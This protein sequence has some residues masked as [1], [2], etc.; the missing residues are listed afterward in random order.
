MATAQA[1]PVHFRTQATGFATVGEAAA[2]QPCDD[3]DAFEG[4]SETIFSKVEAK[5]K[6]RM[7]EGRDHA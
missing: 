2:C 4:E 1:L 3:D 5:I 7:D 6:A